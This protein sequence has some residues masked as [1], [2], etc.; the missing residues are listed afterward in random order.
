MCCRYYTQQK[1]YLKQS[2]TVVYKKHYNSGYMYI[3]NSLCKTK[4]IYL[5]FFK[6]INPIFVSYRITKSATFVV[7]K[8]SKKYFSFAIFFNIVYKRFLVNKFLYASLSTIVIALCYLFLKNVTCEKCL[9]I[10][11]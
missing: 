4:M 2:L 9:L 3:N 5:H 7:N 8:F 10:L 6:Q 11:P 1:N